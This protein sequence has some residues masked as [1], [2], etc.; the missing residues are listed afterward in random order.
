MI[1]GHTSIWI[2]HLRRSDPTLAA[3]LDGSQVSIL[4]LH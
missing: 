1:L 3:L 2:D 4:V